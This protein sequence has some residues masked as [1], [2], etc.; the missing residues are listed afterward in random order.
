MSDV[1]TSFEYFTVFVFF[2]FI[3]KTHTLLSFNSDSL[4]QVIHSFFTRWVHFYPPGSDP[5]LLLNGK[6]FSWLEGSPH[7]ALS[8]CLFFLLYGDFSQGLGS[9]VDIIS[10]DLFLP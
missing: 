6:V 5:S 4:Q 3:M 10:H 1:I 7:V 9:L 2:Q 8:F